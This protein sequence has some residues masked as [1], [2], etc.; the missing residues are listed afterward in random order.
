MFTHITAKNIHWSILNTTIWKLYSRLLVQSK[1]HLIM[2]LFQE[3]EEVF[4]SCSSILEQLTL[5]QDSEDGHTTNGSE[6]WSGIMNIWLLSTSD[7]SRLDISLI[8][9]VQSSQPST[10]YIPDTK[11]NNSAQCGLIKLKN[12][13]LPILDQPKSNLNLLELILSMIT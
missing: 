5:F 11:S 10:T 6:L 4:Y 3:A 7:I 13:K 2:N 1:Y 8:S 12:S 9:L